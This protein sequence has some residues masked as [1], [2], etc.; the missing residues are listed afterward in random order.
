M[1]GGVGAGRQGGRQGRCRRGPPV[2][3]RAGGRRGRRNLSGTRRPALPGV[4]Q[5]RPRPRPRHAPCRDG[6]RWS[7]V[8]AWPGS[9]AV[10]PRRSDWRS[11]AV[12]RPTRCSATSP[13]STTPRPAHRTGRAPPGPHDR[14]R[15]RR[16]RRHLHPPRAR[17]AVPGS[18]LRARV[19]HPD[20]HRPR[21]PLRRAGCPTGS[22]QRGTTSPRRWRSDPAGCRWSR[23]G[24][25]GAA[26]ARPTPGCGP[27]PPRPSAPAAD[28]LGPRRSWRGPRSRPGPRT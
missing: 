10:S 15:E 14:G 16:R 8:A 28:C 23:C 7:P 11:R 13:S 20:R 5:R 12:G 1:G 17:G 22:P 27:P 6:R 26:T 4:V 25:T 19:R 18:G 3:Q 24:W 21:C 2:A 9:T